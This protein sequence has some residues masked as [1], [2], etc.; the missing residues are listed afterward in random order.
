[1]TQNKIKELERELEEIYKR[2]REDESRADALEAKIVEANKILAEHIPIM[3]NKY[4]VRFPE[5]AKPY[6]ELVQRLQK[7]LSQEEK[8]KQ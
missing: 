8:A 5:A 2:H 4:Q 3:L 7:C 6:I 1:M